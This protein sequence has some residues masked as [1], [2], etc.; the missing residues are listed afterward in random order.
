[1]FTRPGLAIQTVR[2]LAITVL[3]LFVLRAAWL[4]LISAYDNDNFPEELAVKVMLMP[5]IF[6]LHMVC[7]GLA[8][9]L[10]PAALMLRKQPRWHRPAGRLAAINVLIAGLTAW[11]VALVAP[12]TPWSAAGF[13]MQGAMWLLLLGKG[14]YHIRR[15]EI[16][17]HRASMILLAAVTSGAIF[18]RVYLALWAVFAQ[19]QHYELFY[20]C[21]A[22]LAWLVPLAG[23]ALWL[24]YSNRRRTH[25]A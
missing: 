8:L 12:V 1:L 19:R 2:T 17:Q 24:R 9:V 21:D 16:A 23:C 22:W 3:C 4:A 11:P 5:V 14:L 18:F 15:R 10:V 13:S 25:V 20:A 7:G 6:P